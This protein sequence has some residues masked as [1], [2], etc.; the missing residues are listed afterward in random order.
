MSKYLPS[1]KGHDVLKNMNIYCPYC[2]W[3]MPDGFANRRRMGSHIGANH[4]EEVAF[5]F[6]TEPDDLEPE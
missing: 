4:Y 2:D 6:G 1:S 5:P 3:H